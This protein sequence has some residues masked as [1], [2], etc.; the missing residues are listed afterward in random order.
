[1]RLVRP[2]QHGE[3]FVKF[4]Y[5]NEI[6]EEEHFV[7][8][9]GCILFCLQSWRKVQEAGI[10]MPSPISVS[11]VDSLLTNTFPFLSPTTPSADSESEL[12]ISMHTSLV[13]AK[14]R[15]FGSKYCCVA[16]NN[17]QE[18]GRYDKCIKYT[19]GRLGQ[20]R[21]KPCSR[22]TTLC[23]RGCHGKNWIQSGLEDLH[24]ELYESYC[25][26]SK[27]MGEDWSKYEKQ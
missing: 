26:C 7:W 19:D 5:E 22:F 20:G 4:A 12:G 13:C 16:A 15:L 17:H 10:Q 11:R 27:S 18:N 24:A 8:Q 9:A 25:L 2:E 23:F 14:T 21:A 6:D 3:K 1:M